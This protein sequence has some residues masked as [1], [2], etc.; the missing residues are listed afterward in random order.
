MSRAEH[1]ERIHR[2]K[3]FIVSWSFV[4]WKHT[5]TKMF[6]NKLRPTE[7]SGAA[8]HQNKPVG[9][10]AVKR[11]V[12]KVH[13][14]MHSAWGGGRVDTGA[15][16]CIRNYIAATQSHTSVSNFISVKPKN[17]LLQ[18]YYTTVNKGESVTCWWSGVFTLA[19]MTMKTYLF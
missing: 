12:C 17:V 1:R 16:D 2:K 14:D 5:C 10:K 8:E 11:K 19:K 6:S 3:R 7:F 9:G 15:L 4:A 13:S 18:I